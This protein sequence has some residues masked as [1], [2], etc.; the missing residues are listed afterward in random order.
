M[1][2]SCITGSACEE[3]GHGNVLVSQK[4]EGDVSNLKPLM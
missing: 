1:H 4:S 2:A 3:K